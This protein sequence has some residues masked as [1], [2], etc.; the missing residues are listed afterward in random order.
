M[1]AT[2]P[3]PSEQAPAPWSGELADVRERLARLE[4]HAEAHDRSSAERHG[5]VLGAVQALQSRLEQVEGRA[6]KIALALAAGAG[7]AAGGAE[8]VKSLLGG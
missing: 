6:W 8:L 4:T 1:P 5:Q 3:R 7:G 2:A